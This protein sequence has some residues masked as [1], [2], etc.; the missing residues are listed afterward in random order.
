VEDCIFAEMDKG[1]AFLMLASA[2]HGG[3]TNATADEYRLLF[4]TFSV[5]GYLR[6]E[7]NQF[8]AVPREVAA[9]YGRDVQAYMGYSLSDPACGYVEEMDPI[10]ILRPELKTGP[11]DF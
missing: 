8:L 6:Q 7:E 4:A 2:Y 5:R 1:D 9:A 11:K 10:F 3:G